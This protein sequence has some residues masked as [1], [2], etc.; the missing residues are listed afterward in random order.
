ML[1]IAG[2]MMTI[3]RAGKMKR[4]NGNINFTGILAAISS[5]L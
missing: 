1:M 4:I 5:A 3:K 2:P